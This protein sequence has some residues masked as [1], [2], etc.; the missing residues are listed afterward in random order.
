MI[1]VSRLSSLEQT[2]SSLIIMNHPPP[3]C[4]QHSRRPRISEDAQCS[5][6]STLSLRALNCCGVLSPSCPTCMGMPSSAP[7]FFSA[8]CR[9][10]QR[11]L[12]FSFSAQSCRLATDF[13]PT[14][15]F[16][17]LLGYGPN[18]FPTFIVI[19][20]PLI[21]ILLITFFQHPLGSLKITLA[22]WAVS[23]ISTRHHLL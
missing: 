22:S 21:S 6:L 14:F 7:L 17:K 9:H 23:Y 10:V 3:S 20:S 1:C 16:E 15:F 13:Y 18:A 8:S 11:L 19:S 2:G 12:R 5:W 4:I